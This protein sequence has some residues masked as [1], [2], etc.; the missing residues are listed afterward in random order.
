MKILSPPKIFCD[1]YESKKSPACHKVQ[2]MSLQSSNES[3]MVFSY[4][5]FIEHFL[6]ISLY[7][8]LGDSGSVNSGT[9][10]KIRSF[11]LRVFVMSMSRYSLFAM[12]RDFQRV[13]D[14]F[15]DCGSPIFRII[16]FCPWD[17]TEC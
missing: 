4:Y 11:C 6:F 5:I 12:C 3:S 2:L 16:S 7:L 14:M 8:E 1:N 15:S 17:V 13:S 9:V 10:I